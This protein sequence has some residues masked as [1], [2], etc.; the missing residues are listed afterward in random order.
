MKTGKANLKYDRMLDLYMRLSD[1][2]IINKEDAAKE[3]QV[4]C[5]SIQRDI[6]ALRNFFSNQTVS[7]GEIAEIVYDREKKGYRL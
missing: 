6:D 7:R 5:R 1:G 4:D 2:E 3:Y